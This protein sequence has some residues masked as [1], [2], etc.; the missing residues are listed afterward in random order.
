MDIQR[1]RFLDDFKKPFMLTF[2]YYGID[3]VEEIEYMFDKVYGKGNYSFTYDLRGFSTKRRSKIHIHSVYHKDG[4][5][6]ETLNGDG[7]GETWL[8]NGK[9]IDYK[10]YNHKLK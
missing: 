2:D 5:Y 10:L 6:L 7:R 9:I 4:G 3:K 1:K 8:T